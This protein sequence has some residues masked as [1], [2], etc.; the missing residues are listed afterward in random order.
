MMVMMMLPMMMTMLLLL[1]TMMLQYV[2]EW[3]RD[4]D[5]VQHSLFDG[6]LMI[7]K[8]EAGGPRLCMSCSPLK[9]DF[10]GRISATGSAAFHVS[11]SRGHV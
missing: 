9:C 8:R 4:E 5:S 10:C 7:E 6:T 1:L 2:H 3:C 11:E